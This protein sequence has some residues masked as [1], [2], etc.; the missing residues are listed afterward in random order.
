MLPTSH[1]K[2]LVEPRVAA[3]AEGPTGVGPLLDQFRSYLF[4]TAQ[5]ALS[6]E[7]SVKVSASDIVQETI[8]QGLRGFEQFRGQSNEQLAHWLHEIL[9]SQVRIER[10]RFARQ[11]RTL[12][13]EE[14]SL[15]TAPAGTDPSPSTAAIKAEDLQQVAIAIRQLTTDGQLAI[16]L[17][18]RE[19]LSFVEIGVR[20]NRSEEAARKLYNRALSQLQ[21]V[22]PRHE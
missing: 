19:Q 20:L 5:A 16:E 8:V 4:A 10:R 1:H 14:G 2:I 3:A 18:H 13:R 21:R 6:R 15:S 12:A 7:L 9:K 22:L 17:R 11:R